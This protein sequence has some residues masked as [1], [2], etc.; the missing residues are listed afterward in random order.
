MSTIPE[1]V[2]RSAEKTLEEFFRAPLLRSGGACL[3]AAEPCPGGFELS[4]LKNGSE[5]IIPLARLLYSPELEQWTLHRPRIEARWSYVPEAGCSLDPGRLLR[6]LV[7]DPLN[8]FWS[9]PA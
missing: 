2:Y 4:F 6:Y 1:L 5:R 8:L 3:V 9:G 7:D